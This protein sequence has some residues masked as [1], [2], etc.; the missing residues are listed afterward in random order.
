MASSLA[1]QT[2]AKEL[3]RRSFRHTPS[4]G[5]GLS[6]T[7]MI[8]RAALQCR[9]AQTRPHYHA[10]TRIPLGQQVC[11]TV[12]V[13]WRF[14]V[15]TMRARASM[16]PNRQLRPRYG[17]TV[18]IEASIEIRACQGGE[19]RCVQTL[20]QHMEECEACGMAVP[21]DLIDHPCFGFEAGCLQ[22]EE[23]PN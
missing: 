6:I 17:I 7:K 16:I 8:V 5:S 18:P 3:R 23:E 14:A 2:Y 20:A 9:V 1:S 21:C 13:R 22:A 11:H 19:T 12:L 10:P 15:A 4:S